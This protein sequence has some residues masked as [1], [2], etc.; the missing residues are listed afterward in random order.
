MRLQLLR[1][2]T[3]TN[4]R[5]ERSIPE[6]RKNEK[7]K[8]TVPKQRYSNQ[9]LRNLFN[10]HVKLQALQNVTTVPSPCYKVTFYQHFQTLHQVL[11]LYQ[12]QNRLNTVRD[13]K[14]WVEPWLVQTA[15][16]MLVDSER[17]YKFGS[18]ERMALAPGIEFKGKKQT[19]RETWNIFGPSLFVANGQA[20]PG[21][22]V[23]ELEREREK[24]KWGRGGGVRVRKQEGKKKTLSPT[25]LS[26]FFRHN[27][28]VITRWETFALLYF[29]PETELALPCYR[30]LEKT[31]SVGIACLKA[32]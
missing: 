21:E 30:R 31:T 13:V 32:G 29:F 22:P 20:F 3:F 17:V 14:R 24:D 12:M 10:H 25:P 4:F 5:T 28:R 18:D 19:F 15:R 6:K 27:F 11:T 9:L 26:I 1:T 7:G 2:K 8:R 16:R 23:K